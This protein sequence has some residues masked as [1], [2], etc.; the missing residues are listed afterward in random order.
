MGA[1]SWLQ[2]ARSQ[3]PLFQFRCWL[4][5]RW[6]KTKTKTMHTTLYNKFASAFLLQSLLSTVSWRKNVITIE[7]SILLVED[8]VFSQLLQYW[9]ATGTFQLAAAR[10]W[11][12]KSPL[13][14]H[15]RIFQEYRLW[16]FVQLLRTLF[17]SFADLQLFSCCGDRF[18]RLFDLMD[19]SDP[20]LQSNSTL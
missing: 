5:P 12:W 15:F 4:R 11:A 8:K 10:I 16:R 20:R 14:L 13:E 6:R 2:I 17:W 1:T 19:Q 3:L 7:V 18:E 9:I